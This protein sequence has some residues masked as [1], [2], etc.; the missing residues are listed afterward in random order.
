MCLN[1]INLVNKERQ[2]KTGSAEL[3]KMVFCI[4]AV[5]KL[6][7]LKIISFLLKNR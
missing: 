1:K 3:I 4:C 2:E 7:K 6:Q 5:G